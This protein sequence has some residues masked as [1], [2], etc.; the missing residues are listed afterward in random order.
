M[1]EQWFIL[2]S[3]QRFGPYPVDHL[4]SFL[5]QGLLR[6]EETLVR[7]DGG[8]PVKA[9]D[10]LALA[11]SPAPPP[12]P[13]PPPPPVPVSATEPQAAPVPP[14]AAPAPA[15]APAEGMLPLILRSGGLLW[16]KLSLRQRILFIAIGLLI[17]V[18]VV[19]SLLSKGGSE[20]GEKSLWGVLGDLGVVSGVV[21]LTFGV[22]Q[23]YLEKKL[24]GTDAPVS[25]APPAA[26][27][28]PDMP[29]LAPAPNQVE[30]GSLFV[31]LSIHQWL[32]TLHVVFLAG[33]AGAVVAGFMLG[34]TSLLVT[35]TA[36]AIVGLLIGLLSVRLDL[37]LA[38]WREA[39][40]R[41][42]L[43]TQDLTLSK[44]TGFSALLPAVP[45][46][47]C[48]CTFLGPYANWIWFV[49]AA[50]VCLPVVHVIQR[51]APAMEPFRNSAGAWIAGGYLGVMFVSCAIL[52][53]LITR[54]GGPLPSWMVGTWEEKG[55]KGAKIEFT[56]GG[57]ALITGWHGS[58]DR[59]QDFKCKKKDDSHLILEADYGFEAGEIETL[60][61]TELVVKLYSENR[62][63]TRA[64]G[65]GGGGNGKA[66]ADSRLIGKWKKQKPTRGFAEQMVT[67]TEGGTF[68]YSA[69]RAGR[70]DTET[71]SS[72]FTWVAKD[73]IQL[74]SR[75]S[76]GDLGEISLDF[77]SDDE[78]ILKYHGS[79]FKLDGVNGTFLRVK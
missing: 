65:D 67:V 38:E 43:T 26:T 11:P 9:A 2:R 69:T 66:E 4:R 8:P 56:K 35:G 18:L 48:A 5:A 77:V 58:S 7:S 23:K 70:E 75:G 39:S 31:G 73:R 19:W 50:L 10:V 37:A 30:M 17:L 40:H 45:T 53:S 28:T 34:P 3:D 54:G 59:T 6:G 25:A 12:P 29:V 72:K 13:P 71:E 16:K 60:S 55:G 61:R 78:I 63:F 64:E 49:Y 20:S 41:A 62:K 1:A 44:L 68:L 76:K 57:K 22:L 52:A 74:G 24:I 14:A 46:L 27:A 33:L 47:A 51:L 42:A 15:P 21:G 79:S 32:V 36:L